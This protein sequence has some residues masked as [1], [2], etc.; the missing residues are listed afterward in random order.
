LFTLKRYQQ[1]ASDRLVE[2]TLDLI[3][4]EGNR[5][6]ILEAPTGSGKTIIASEYINKILEESQEKSLSFIWASPRPKLTLQSKNKVSRYTSEKKL[7]DCSTFYDLEENRISQNEILFVNW[8]SIN[9]ENNIFRAPNEKGNYL[10]EIV[11]NTHLSGNEIILIIDESHF[12]APTDTTQ[13]L[14]KLINPRVI[15]EISATPILERVF[16]EKVPVRIEDVKEEEM[17]K[18]SVIFN[19]GYEKELFKNKTI[20]NSEETNDEII[21][22]DALKKRSSLDKAYKEINEDIKP[23]MLI[24]LPVSKKADEDFQKDKI[25]KILHEKHDISIENKKLAIYLANDNRNYNE[26]RIQRNNDETEVLIFKQA[27]ALGWD[28]PR[29]QVLLLMRDWKS[30]NFSIQTVG[31]I[32]RVPKPEVGYLEND[33]LNHSYIYT[34]LKEI[35]WLEDISRNYIHFKRSDLVLESSHIFNSVHKMREKK[36]D[37]LGADFVKF[38]EDSTQKYKLSDQIDLSLNKVSDEILLEMSVNDV[39]SLKGGRL[40]ESSS[41]ELTNPEDIQYL[42]DNFVKSNLSPFSPQERSIKRVNDAIYDFFVTKYEFDYGDI[43]IQ[44]IVLDKKNIN[45]FKNVIF[46]ALDEYHSYYRESDRELMIE[47]AE[48][49]FPKFIDYFADAIEID[50]NKSIMQPFLQSNISEPERNFIK[51]LDDHHNVEWWYKNGESD[52]K[53]FAV[54]Y[55]KDDDKKPFYVD[56]IIG[57]KSGL[58]WLIDTKSGITITTSREKIDGLNAYVKKNKKIKG[59]IAANTKRDQTGSW[60]IFSKNSKSLKD[61]EFENWEFLNF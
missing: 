22:Q 46:Q 18:K 34:N 37:R 23:L 25:I 38:F 28:C 9:Q 26:E 60:K 31:R 5:T 7:L 43:E 8:E 4:L 51:F 53:Y 39:S 2:Y 3:K 12:Q 49:K 55:I 36:K 61:N 11:Q 15:I 56:F 21:I 17:I 48:W 20:R 32:M 33:I 35:T 44:K 58:I 54:P 13:S 59:G 29:A 24:Q 30:L 10:E 47:N 50:V 45:H 52:S 41:F 40:L 14:I 27:I 6:I 42:F 57:L 1:K 16:D 19:E